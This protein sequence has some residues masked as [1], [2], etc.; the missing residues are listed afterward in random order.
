YRGIMDLDIRFDARDGQYKLLDFNPRVGAQFRIFQNAAG[1]DVARAAHL[2]LT[3]RSL[4]SG[5]A[6][7]DRRF[8]VENY[9]TLAAIGYMRRGELSL[10]SWLAT[11]RG[12]NEAA[13]FARDDLLP[14]GLMCLRMAWRAVERPFGGRRST[15]QRPPRFRPGRGAPSHRL[16]AHRVA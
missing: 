8:F 10:R 1:I 11:V 3:G 2:D 13:W 15:P 4:P 9:D 6:M 5:L 16:G 7:A 14:F 12:V